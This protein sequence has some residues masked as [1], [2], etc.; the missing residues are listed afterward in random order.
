MAGGSSND[1][2]IGLGS[3]LRKAREHRGVT[4]DAASRD[5]KLSVDHLRALEDE[6]FDA[7]LGDVY[8][9][10]SL[11]TYAAYLGL[12]PEKVVGIYA[13]HVD[14]PGPPPP[15]AKLGRV[16]RAIA[17]TRIRDNQ[18]LMVI[19]AAIALLVAVVFGLVSRGHSTPEAASLPSVAEPPEPADRSIDAVV[20][21]IRD[22]EIV[23][24]ADGVRTRYELTAG[25]TR[26]FT[27]EVSLALE[28]EDGAAFRL[29]VNGI[30]YGFPGS[31]GAPW[32]DGWTFGS[33]SG[34]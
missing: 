2:L 27:A 33:A 23:A 15:P 8:V 9:R 14:D 1:T 6:D 16:E 25:E 20:E 3:A 28:A 29:T 32:S 17:A 13:R 30:A 26:T 34:A 11:R 21:A 31:P 22:V 4:R 18:R 5:T 10:G 19:L 24:D 12:D 7:L